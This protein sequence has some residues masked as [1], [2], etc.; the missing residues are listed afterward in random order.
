MR[1]RI[2][3]QGTVLLTMGESPPAVEPMGALAA[4]APAPQT[5]MRL[6]GRGEQV[7]LVDPLTGAGMIYTVTQVVHLYGVSATTG[8]MDVTGVDVEV[9]PTE[10][11]RYPGDP[12]A[13]GE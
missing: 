8:G 10:P 6:P 7:H 3:D 12:T 9:R 5:P 1:V 4:E 13:G 11:S 2:V